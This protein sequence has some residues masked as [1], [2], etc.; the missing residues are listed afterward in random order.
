MTS[1]R[2]LAQSIT[3]LAVLSVVGGACTRSDERGGVTSSV[4]SVRSD[5][6]REALRSVP[7]PDLTGL[8]IPVQD[9]VRERF[10]V[11]EQRRA[12][13]GT[14]DAELGA[15]YGDLGLILMAAE[16]ERPALSSFI[17]AEALA[18]AAP[19]WPYYRGQ[20][21]VVRGEH[22]EAEVA[23]ERALVLRADDFPTLVQ[24]G[25]MALAHGRPEGAER[26]FRQALALEPRSAAAL[27]GMGRAV[28]A[29]GD[30][31][32]AVEYLKRALTMEPDAT[33]LHYPLALA[34][35]GLGDLTG[36][37]AQLRLR[38]GGEPRVSDPLMEEYDGL[39]E[40]AL[41]Y[42][43]R[44]TKAM[45]IQ[46]WAVAAALFREGLE[47]EPENAALG[48]ALGTA[49]TQL[50]EV[51]AAVE[52]FEEVL[53]WS[54]NYASAHFSLGVMQASNGRFSEARARFAAVVTHEPDHVQARL[55]LADILRMMGRQEAML[56]HLDHVVEVD[57][58]RVEAWIAGADVLIGLERYEE[59]RDWLD[60]AS[61]VHP[62]LVE[63]AS[64]RETVEA[65][66][67]L[68]RAFR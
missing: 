6:G 17:N 46:E 44:G 59:A 67:E 27:G 36:A 40:S 14:P 57:P 47:L 65:V 23:F 45:L 41:A 20:L 54:P 28:L 8:P 12:R 5:G 29:Q 31:A 39:L 55:L 10:A 7:L 61:K 4:A 16:Y 53:R 52:Q 30:H 22:A 37:D 43:N 1:G 68:R 63:I 11:L 24:L 56:P 66:L 38:G 15:A 9:Q 21:H 62:E 58:R 2:F 32:T 18:P 26:R 25:D 60:A 50:G 19:R 35:R 49:L 3:V 42:L 48:H 64:L 34:Y 33:S 13:P 51:D